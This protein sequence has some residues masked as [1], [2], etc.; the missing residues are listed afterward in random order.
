MLAGGLNA[1]QNT[2][3][4]TSA[5]FLVII[6]GLAVAFWKELAQDRRAAAA[7]MGG[8][9]IGTTAAPTV[10]AASDGLPAE[11]RPTSSPAR[12]PRQAGTHTVFAC[13]A[14]RARV[15]RRSHRCTAPAVSPTAHAEPWR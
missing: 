14:L 7:A 10:P 2:V 13:R 4:V 12:S 6:A 9:V 5:P 15:T 11:R 8:A 1:L 3:I